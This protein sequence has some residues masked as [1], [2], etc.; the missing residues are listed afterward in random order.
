V[1]VIIYHEFREGNVTDG[2]L[3]AIQE[4][5]EAV[6]EGKRIVHVSLDSEYYQSSVIN[7]L[8]QRQVGF[9]I[10]AV[11]DSAVKEVIRGIKQWSP[12]ID[13]D[14]IQTD[15]QTDDDTYNEQNRGVLSSCSA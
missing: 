10:V 6:S 7:Y 1:P 12:Y 5:F 9:C 3:R 11:Q 13:S 8:Q 4:A 2:Q 14:G 15:R